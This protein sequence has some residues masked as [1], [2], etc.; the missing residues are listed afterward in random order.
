MKCI[1]S[2]QAIDAKYTKAAAIVGPDQEVIFE[3]EEITLDIPE[4]MEN[5]SIH[6]SWSKSIIWYSLKQTE[7][8][9]SVLLTFKKIKKLMSG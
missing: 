9:N 6:P 7:T 1:L 3:G 2:L 4:W 8:F 5:N